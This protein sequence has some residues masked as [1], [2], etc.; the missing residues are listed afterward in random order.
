VQ[1]TDTNAEVG[2]AIDEA[3]LQ[4][5]GRWGN[6]ASVEIIRRDHNRGCAAGFNAGLRH[7]SPR[8]QYLTGF[9]HSRADY[10]VD[11][12]EECSRNNSA[13]WALILNDDVAFRPGDLA[14]LSAGMHAHAIHMPEAQHGFVTFK[15]TFTDRGTARSW[16][17]RPPF[18]A[19][20]VTTAALELIGLFDENLW[21]AYKED[22][23]Y[24]IR[25]GHIGIDCIES[26]V[27]DNGVRLIHGN[28]GFV[29]YQPGSAGAGANRIVGDT[30]GARYIR[31]KW[32]ALNHVPPTRQ[33][34]NTRSGALFD[35]KLD[36]HR[37]ERMATARNALDRC[38]KSKQQEEC[39]KSILT[40]SVC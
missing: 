35:W 9:K 11:K 5:R 31:K 34:F 28:E 14:R 38:L 20:A 6:H 39:T 24:C 29:G 1:S 26:D 18:C 15:Y 2:R 22:N 37:L 25:L 16:E 32:G 3:L 19:F 30:C 8:R 27:I 4:Y 36:K 40:D 12:T 13:P 23:E 21:P 33:P 17:A 10:C 7:A